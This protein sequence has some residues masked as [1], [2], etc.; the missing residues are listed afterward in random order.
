METTDKSRSCRFI[1]STTTITKLQRNAAS[2]RLLGLSGKNRNL[3]Q[4]HGL[5][6]GLLPPI[7]KVTG[8]PHYFRRNLIPNNTHWRRRS[9]DGE[10]R[11]SYFNIYLVM[12]IYRF[13][14]LKLVKQGVATFKMKDEMKC[15]SGGIKPLTDRASDPGPSENRGNKPLSQRLNILQENKMRKTKTKVAW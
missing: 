1:A 11:V 10:V 13:G 14:N 3:R 6:R 2:P 9:R 4:P 8:V 5:P 7:Q 15:R 12:G